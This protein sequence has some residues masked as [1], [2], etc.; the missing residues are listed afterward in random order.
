MCKRYGKRGDMEEIIK[1]S[2][3][4]GNR[5]GGGGGDC[6]RWV[7]VESRNSST[8]ELLFLLS[9]ASKAVHRHSVGAVALGVALLVALKAK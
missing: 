5:G 8:I 9:S 3:N 2:R 7:K 1:L 6:Y 4:E